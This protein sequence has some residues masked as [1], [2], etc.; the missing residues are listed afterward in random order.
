VAG[1]LCNEPKQTLFAIVH[2]RFERVIAQQLRIN[3]MR[4]EIAVG[5]DGTPGVDR[6]QHR[7]APQIR[8]DKL[9]LPQRSGTKCRVRPPR[10]TAS[11]RL[12]ELE[13][14]LVGRLG[15]RLRGEIVRVFGMAPEIA[16]AHELEA[17]R[18]DLTAQ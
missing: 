10:A 17:G 7:S 13:H 9:P 1:G 6:N 4:L 8:A 12:L 16:L 15:R 14:E 2:E 5:Q 18:L 11:L 3:A